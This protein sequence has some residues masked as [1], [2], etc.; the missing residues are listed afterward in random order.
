MSTAVMESADRNGRVP[1]LH[2]VQMPRLFR[3]VTRLVAFA[4][5]AL[6]IALLLLPWQQNVRGEGRVVAYAPL[7]RQQPID[8]PIDGR[9]MQWWVAEGSEVEIGDPLFEITDNDPQLIGRLEE[10]LSA[11]KDNLQFENDKAGSYEGQVQAYRDAQRLALLAATE[12]VE[13]AVQRIEAALHA[14]DAAEVAELT[15]ELNLERKKELRQDGLA[16]EREL[17]LAR[18]EA[19]KATLDVARSKAA[20]EAARR[21]KES[22]EAEKGKTRADFDAR[23]KTSEANRQD[24]SGKAASSRSKVLD[25]ETKLARQQTQRVVAPVRG[26]VL[27]LMGNQGGEFVKAGDILLVLVPATEKLAVEM[28]VDGNDM[29]LL[30]SGRKVRL[31]FEGWPAVQF[32]GWPSVAVGTFGGQVTFVDATDNGQGQFRVVIQPDP[33]DQPWPSRRFLRQGVQAKGW[34]LLEE[35]TLGYEFWRRLNGFPPVIASMEPK[36]KGK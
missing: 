12:R 4:V 14:V 25:L 21:E 16:S 10:Q 24:A 17:E 15:A 32:A 13:M 35:V 27:R 34:V 3:W 6:P 29:P 1:A 22:L 2:L 7:E 9:V 26:T 20:L 11:A 8:A 31:Q 28:W 18:L 33:Q 5:V 23:V 36:E 19:R 30:S